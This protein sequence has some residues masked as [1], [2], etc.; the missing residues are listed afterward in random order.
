[1]KL[2]NALIWHDKDNRLIFRHL[3]IVYNEFLLPFWIY[4]FQVIPL[5][6]LEIFVTLISRDVQNFFTQLS[7]P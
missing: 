4:P 1:M 3:S 6:F 2:F 5:P 7:I